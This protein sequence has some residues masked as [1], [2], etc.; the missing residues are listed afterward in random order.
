[1]LKHATI[2]PRSC[3]R[4]STQKIKKF[5]FGTISIYSCLNI[6]TVT[7][8]NGLLVIGTSMVDAGWLVFISLPLDH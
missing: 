7:W 5:L 3:S 6:L 2:H 1:M 4:F 8:G